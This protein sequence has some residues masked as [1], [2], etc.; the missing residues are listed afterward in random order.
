MGSLAKEASRGFFLAIDAREKKFSIAGLSD[1]LHE[2]GAGDVTAIHLEAS[3]SPQG[4]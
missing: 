4:T 3:E 1:L 2:L